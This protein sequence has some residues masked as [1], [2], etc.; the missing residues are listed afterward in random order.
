[1][2]ARIDVTSATCDNCRFFFFGFCR[3]YPPTVFYNPLPEEEG[4][5]ETLSEWPTVEAD[6]WCGE[7]QVRREPGDRG[8][9]PNR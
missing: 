1:M 8:V 5:E 6:D 2:A 9:A 7:H 3:R 4:T